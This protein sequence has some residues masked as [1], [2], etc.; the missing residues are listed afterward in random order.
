MDLFNF[1]DSKDLTPFLV[2]GNIKNIL[3]S[4]KAVYKNEFN[5]DEVEAYDIVDYLMQK[6]FIYNINVNLEYEWILT[7][8]S[9]KKQLTT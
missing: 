8:N 3:T 7:N 5:F 4:L 1:L 6:R 2:D 9:L